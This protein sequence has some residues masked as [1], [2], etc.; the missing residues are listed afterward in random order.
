MINWRNNPWR[1]VCTAGLEWTLPQTHCEMWIFGNFSNPA[2]KHLGPQTHPPGCG[3]T[4]P[5]PVSAGWGAVSHAGTRCRCSNGEFCSGLCWFPLAGIPK[6]LWKGWSR[7]VSPPPN[8]SEAQCAPHWG[9]RVHRSSLISSLT[10]QP[11]RVGPGPNPTQSTPEPNGQQLIGLIGS[12]DSP[13][14]TVSHTKVFG[15]HLWLLSAER[16]APWGHSRCPW[17]TAV[18]PTVSHKHGPR[19]IQ[20]SPPFPVNKGTRK[21]MVP[22]EGAVFPGLLGRG[23]EE[24]PACW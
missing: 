13:R 20:A 23:A 24:P 16:V 15:K 1:R 22:S 10:L 4:C 12:P 2:L 19:S 7:P 18:I 11:S 3:Q 5:A 9:P 6:G 8:L 14:L 17:A 21:W